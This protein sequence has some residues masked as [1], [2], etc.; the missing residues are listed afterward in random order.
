MGVLP[1]S[2]F[3]INHIVLLYNPRLQSWVFDVSKM[4]ILYSAVLEEFAHHDKY[5]T[6]RIFI[7]ILP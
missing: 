6:D 7:R 4:K 3:P 2:R 1:E 5:Y